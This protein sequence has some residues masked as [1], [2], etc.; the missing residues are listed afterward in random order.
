MVVFPNAKINIGLHITRKREDGFHELE[1]IFYPVKDLYDVLEVVKST[2]MQFDIN[3]TDLQIPEADNIVLKAYQLLKEK[4]NI[5]P[6]HIHLHKRIPHG[7][8]LGGGSA[9]AAFMLKACNDLF[10]LNIANQELA[11]Y[12]AQLGSDCPF[13]IYNQA[14]HGSGRGEILEALALDLSAYHLAIVKPSTYISTKQAFSL[15]TPKFPQQS[16][17]ELISAA[18]QN[19]IGEIINDFEAPI[20]AHFPELQN[21]KEQLIQNGALYASMSGSGSCFFGLFKAPVALPFEEVYWSKA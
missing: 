1:T 5:G 15:I 21:I 8:G 14:M 18:L 13:F 16:L 2:A 6:V 19:W 7:A 3:G 10:E 9:D 4:Y 17:R 11:E 12:A 20:L